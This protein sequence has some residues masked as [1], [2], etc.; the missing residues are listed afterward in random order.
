MWAMCVLERV[1]TVQVAK[2]KK[3]INLVLKMNQY[4]FAKFLHMGLGLSATDGGQRDVQK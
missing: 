3:G 1:P 2:K 4:I